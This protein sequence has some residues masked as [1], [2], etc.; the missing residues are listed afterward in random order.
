MVRLD[1]STRIVLAQDATPTVRRAAAYLKQRLYDR[2]GLNPQIVADQQPRAGD[3]VLR[4]ISS[5]STVNSATQEVILVDVKRDAG[6]S[7]V[8]CSFSKDNLALASVGRFLRGLSFEDHT[9]AWQGGTIRESPAFPLRGVTLAN[10]KQNNTY[11]KWDWTQ[12]EDYLTELAAWGAN[13]VILYPLHPTRWR[14]ALPFDDPPWF[15]SP[16]LQA[17]FQRQFEIQ[18]R[19]PELC[20]ELGMRYGVWI[21]PNDVFPE[22]VK[23]NPAL[24]RFGGT[25]VCPHM[26]EALDS[27]MGIRRKLFELLPR[28]D[29]LFIPSHDD[30]GCPGCE[31]CNPWVETYLDLV[32][33]QAALARAV[34]PECKVWVSQQ[35]LSFDETERLAKWLATEQPEWVEAVAFGPF[36]EIATFAAGAS[37]DGYPLG[38]DRTGPVA[39]LR[40]QVPAQYKVV[41]YPDITHTWHCQYPVTFMDT[42]I[43]YVWRREDGPAFRPAEMCQIHEATSPFGHGSAPYSEGNTDDLNKFVW[44]AKDWCASRNALD[45][46]RE[47]ARWF[48]GEDVEDAVVRAIQ[49]LEAAL[50]RPLYPGHEIE[51]LYKLVREVEK[52]KPGVIN[53][54]R[55]LLIRIGALMLKYLQE[56]HVRDRLVLAQIQYRAAEWKHLRDPVPAIERG[57]EWLALKLSQTG[58]LLEEIV[59]TRDKLFRLQKLNVRGVSNLQASYVGLERVLKQWREVVADLKKG[60]VPGYQELYRRLAEPV[61]ACESAMLQWH[62]GDQ[63]VASL[64]EFE[65]EK[66]PPTW[67][68]N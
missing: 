56:V 44:L 29:I 67:N 19:I 50:G 25:F 58:S 37:G 27:I 18:L 62:R 31:Q 64:V 2:C 46:V 54:W 34:H 8:R 41:L 1:I 21:P 28:L 65:W 15:E 55:W 16:E 30:G 12:W 47:Y 13:L 36:S 43:Q 38:G 61:W 48:V 7:Y 60:Q 9:A 23:R 49:L 66:S 20:Q 5:C 53:N 35:G 11:D 51:E 4:Q 6:G 10:H 33:R 17:E 52:R 63:L 14:G 24:T 45:V 32:K 57:I 40:R 26:P 68:W 22:Q 42:V 59:E 3:V 39:L